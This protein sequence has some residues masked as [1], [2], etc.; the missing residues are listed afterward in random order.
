MKTTM[1]K[2]VVHAAAALA[3]AALVS[4]CGT[5]GPDFAAPKSV[6]TPAYRHAAAEPQDQA[7]R[8]PADWWTVFGD[9]TLTQL[10]QRALRDNP[11]VRAAAQ[12][13][14]QAQAQL[15][16]VRANQLPTVGVSAGG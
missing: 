9:T 8:L 3:V 5:L 11:N 14:V 6:D 15:G 12:R 10:E 16:V 7:A 4:A 2:P 1:F 13:L